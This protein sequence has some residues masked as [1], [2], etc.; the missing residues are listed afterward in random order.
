M[1]LEFSVMNI[2]S[3]AM[4]E[5]KTVT[6]KRDGSVV[7]TTRKNPV[8]SGVVVISS[9]VLLLCYLDGGSGAISKSLGK[10]CVNCSKSVT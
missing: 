3:N 5:E 10:V 2:L 1:G 9:T 4:G 8:I 6:T 7:I